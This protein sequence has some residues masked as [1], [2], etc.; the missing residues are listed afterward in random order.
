MTGHAC[1]FRDEQVTLLRWLPGPRS[2]HRT[3]HNSTP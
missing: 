2:E 1:G 3:R